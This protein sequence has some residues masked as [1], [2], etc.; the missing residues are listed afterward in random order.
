MLPLL[1]SVFQ[2]LDQPR[3]RI[4]LE[5]LRTH[6]SSHLGRFIVCVCACL[7]CQ[8]CIQYVCVVCSIQLNLKIKRGTIFYFSLSYVTFLFSQFKFY[9]KFTQKHAPNTNISYI[10]HLKNTFHNTR[11]CRQ[12][13]IRILIKLKILY[14]DMC[15]SVF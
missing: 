13:Q 5:F 8:V 10:K 2:L 1:L 6:I 4:H 3:E 7:R 12:S 9:V 15:F 14:R 11:R